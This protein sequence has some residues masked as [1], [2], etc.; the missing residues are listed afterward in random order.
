[1]GAFAVPSQTKGGDF[2]ALVGAFRLPVVLRRIPKRPRRFTFAGC[3]L[4]FR[5][6]LKVAASWEER[7]EK[8][9]PRMMAT[10]PKR[11]SYTERLQHQ[12]E[13]LDYHKGS[14][15]EIQSDSQGCGGPKEIFEVE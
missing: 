11:D 2:V 1:M 14:K 13:Y 15:K 8:V 10:M 9:Y 7:Q 12:S 3:A 4:L 5:D 6:F